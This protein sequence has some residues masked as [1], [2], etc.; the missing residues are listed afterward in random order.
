MHRQAAVETEVKLDTAQPS[1]SQQIRDLEY[2]VGK[3]RAGGPSLAGARRSTGRGVKKPGGEIDPA[4]LLPV[5]ESG[6][7]VLAVGFRVG[8]SRMD[9]PGALDVGNRAVDR[10]A[11]DGRVMPDGDRVVTLKRLE[12]LQNDHPVI[13]MIHNGEGVFAR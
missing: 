1:L 7:Q 12:R 4:G 13:E 6:L 3:L 5:G 11:V 8:G 2:E 9:L 10:G